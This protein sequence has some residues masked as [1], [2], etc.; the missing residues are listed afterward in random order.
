[1]NEN[2]NSLDFSNNNEV[3]N[4]Q[5]L[6][7]FKKLT[8]INSNG[9]SSKSKISH[10]LQFIPYFCI[11]I[12][13]YILFFINYLKTN[14]SYEENIHYIN[15]SP[16]SICHNYIKNFEICLNDS[17]KS[18][19]MLKKEGNKYFYDTTVICKKENDKLQLCFD[20]VQLFS[21]KCQIYLNDLYL[22]KNKYKNSIK[23]CLNSNLIG[24]WKNYNII[25]IIKVYDDL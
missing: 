11:I 19:S 23:N 7:G 4:N 16:I 22:C 2:N 12:F 25:D 6:N 18:A 17:Q 10:S 20:K 9:K 13:V 14:K 15:L 3:M 5:N 8:V 1:M 21:Q 24:C